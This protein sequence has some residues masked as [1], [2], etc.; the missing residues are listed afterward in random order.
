VGTPHLLVVDDEPIVRRVTVRAA[1][2]AGYTVSEA[3]DGL[4]AIELFSADPSGVDGVVLDM[5]MPRM[6]GAQ[7]YRALRNLRPDLPIVCVSGYALDEDARLHLG[8]DVLFLAKP[9][10]DD[11]L[12]AALKRAFLGMVPPSRP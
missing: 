12:A 7:C 4:E 2:R 11:D 5:S 9:F 1:Q 3:A 8:G 10:D 6:N